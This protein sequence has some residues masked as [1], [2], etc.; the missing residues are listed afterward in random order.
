[1]PGDWIPADCSLKVG[2]VEVPEL[3]EF[4][5]KPGDEPTQIES[6]TD[7]VT[8]FQE[9][10]QKPTGSFKAKITSQALQTLEDYRVN[11]TEVPIVFVAPH[12]TCTI[13]G[14]RLGP[15]DTGGSLKDMWMVTVNFKGKT[16]RRRFG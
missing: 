14:A 10:W 9:T 4:D 3:D 8:G 6:A 13:T 7:G 1:M 2:A 16:M 11:K 12:F 5:A 15:I